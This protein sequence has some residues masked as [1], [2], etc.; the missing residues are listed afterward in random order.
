MNKVSEDPARALEK[1]MA[2]ANSENA[3]LHRPERYQRESRKQ[4]ENLRQPIAALEPGAI[5]ALS[6]GSI[7]GS[8]ASD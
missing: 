7:P 4:M 5:G 2:H 8:L 6:Y 1:A 3:R